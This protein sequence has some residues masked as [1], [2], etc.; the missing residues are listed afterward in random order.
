[1]FPV[2]LT[3]ESC[4][5]FRILSVKAFISRYRPAIGV[6]W[7]GGWKRR[8]KERKTLPVLTLVKPSKKGANLL[9]YLV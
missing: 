3:G 5:L 1:M 4:A 8:A 6:R 7:Q 2:I 9:Y